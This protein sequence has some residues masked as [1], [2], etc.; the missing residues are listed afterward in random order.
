MQVQRLNTALRTAILTPTE[1]A[2]PNPPAAAHLRGQ[3]RFRQAKSTPF[4][5]HFCELPAKVP[6][7]ALTTIETVRRRPGALQGSRPKPPGDRPGR[8]RAPGPKAVRG[9]F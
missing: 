9:P 4:P 3:I 7:D 2:G 6:A 1:R 5:S 8:T